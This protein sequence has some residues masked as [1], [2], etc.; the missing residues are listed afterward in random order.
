MKNIIS[1]IPKGANVKIMDLKIDVAVQVEYMRM[2]EKNGKASISDKAAATMQERLLNPDTKP[3]VKKNILQKLSQVDKVDV[4]RFLE[5][6][7]DKT[8][9]DLRQFAQLAAFHSQMNMEGALLGERPTVLLSGLGGK[10]NAC[11][12][13]WR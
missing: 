4:L 12:T 6:Y 8:D 7:A 10:T 5:Q 9:S 1:K 3:Y 13:L 11:A 2:L